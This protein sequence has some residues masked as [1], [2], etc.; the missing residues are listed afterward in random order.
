MEEEIKVL[1]V[2]DELSVRRGLRMRMELEP[3]LAVVGEAGDGLEAI[4]SARALCPAP[5]RAVHTPFCRDFA[6]SEPTLAFC[7]SA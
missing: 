5:W 3:D 4:E 2:D 6:C 1:L 7:A